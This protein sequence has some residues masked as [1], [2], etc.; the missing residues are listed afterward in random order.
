M[1]DAGKADGTIRDD[2][3]AGDY[4]QL[5]AAFWR[6]TPGPDDRS[7][8]MIALVLDGLRAT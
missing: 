2:A 3:D 1:L 8:R 5:T 7:P 6:A 4:L